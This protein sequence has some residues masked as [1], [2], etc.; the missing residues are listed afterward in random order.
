MNIK[1]IVNKLRKSI[2]SINV[3]KAI[4][5]SDTET[6][7]RDHIINPFFEEVL[8]YSKMDDFIPEYIADMKDRKGKKVDMAINLGK[9]DPFIFV[10]CKKVDNKLNDKNLRQLYEYCRDTPAV[11]VGILTNGLVYD[12]YSKEAIQTNYHNPFFTFNIQEYDSFDLEILALFYRSNIEMKKIKEY[13]EE[14]YFLDK[15]EDA[16]YSVLSD[17]DELT[18]LVFKEMGGK[19]SSDRVLSQI[20]ESINSITLKTAVDRITKNEIHDS[21]SGIITTDEEEMFFSIV[22]TI[23]AMSSKKMSQQISRIVKKDFK[24]KFT[25]LVD[26]NQNKN[27]CTLIVNKTSKQIIINGLKHPINEISADEITP[28]KNDLIKVAKEYFD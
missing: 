14:V 16:L 27:I 8:N 5:F 20:K 13:S 21:N 26:G 6:G 24:T 3:E 4:K 2:E 19:R 25:I 23:L 28:L 11:Q 12:F 18:K 1:T 22:K 10:E 9:N 15:F 17:N 7:T